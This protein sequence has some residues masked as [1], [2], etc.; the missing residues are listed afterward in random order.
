MTGVATPIDVR[1]M[2]VIHSVFRR[3]LRLAGAS[4]RRVPE[5][6]RAQA[7]RVA[8]GIAFVLQLLEH[9]HQGEDRLLWPLVAERVRQ[10]DAALVELMT[11][12]HRAVDR[13]EKVA[14]QAMD[15]WRADP[16]ASNRDAAADA[17]DTLYAGAA[18]HLD[19]EEQRLL[20]IVATTVTQEEWN[21]LGEE[22][23]ASIP[24]DERGLIMGMFM[25]DGDPEVTA[26]MRRQA[27][28]VVR[29][30]IALTAPRTYARWARQVHGTARP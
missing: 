21:R 29:Q 25:Y 23:M 1:D 9:H 4:I 26:E 19:A 16:T 22:G 10:E 5:G 8:D 30:L 11:E 18:E 12:Q 27:P 24:K 2:Q 13:D 17:F 20:P 14:R 6:D 15:T 28:P 7:Q 3:D